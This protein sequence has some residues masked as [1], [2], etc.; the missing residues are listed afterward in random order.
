MSAA[1]ARRALAWALLSAAF[2]GCTTTVRVPVVKEA[3][4]CKPSPELFAACGAPGVIQQGITFGEMIDMSRSDREKL[5]EC[6][7]RHKFLADAIAD[8]NDKIDKYNAEI[9]QFNA[10]YAGKQ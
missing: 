9:D 3:L 6:A 8:C 5:R 4:R 1:G 10:R 2:S 7:L